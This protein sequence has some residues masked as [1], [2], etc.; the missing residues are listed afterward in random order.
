MG[1]PKSACASS[2]NVL[3]SPPGV[4]FLRS[5]TPKLPLD[6]FGDDSSAVRAGLLLVA[7]ACAAALAAISGSFRIRM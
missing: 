1:T 4:W 5:T 2:S 6:F 7:T 3:T